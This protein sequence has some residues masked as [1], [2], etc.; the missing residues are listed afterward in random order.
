M[1]WGPSTEGK[2]PFDQSPDPP[3]GVY[4]AIDVTYTY[5]GLGSYFFTTCALAE[6]QDVV[7]WGAGNTRVPYVHYHRGSYAVAL[8]GPWDFCGLTTGGEATCQGSGGHELPALTGDYGDGV[9]YTAI[10]ESDRFR[11]AITDAG[12][13][14]CEA[15]PSL[16]GNVR[17]MNPP[18]PAP[19]RFIAVSVG[20]SHA[21]ALGMI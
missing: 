15:M 9:R 4:E 5:D 16:Q 1:C 17:A 21:C 14:V 18:D 2:T 12:K 11:C 6:T 20:R 10:S 7:C 8:A 13:A 3:A 19:G